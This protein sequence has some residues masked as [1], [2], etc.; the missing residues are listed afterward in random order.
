MKPL[1]MNKY[2]KKIVISKPGGYDCL[3][4]KNAPLE[5]MENLQADELLIK[6][7]AAGVN[8]A[9]VC[10]RWGLYSSAKKFVGWPITPGFEFSGYIVATGSKVETFKPGIPVFGISFFGAYSQ[11]LVVKSWQ[12]YPLLEQY[13]FTLEQAAG[14]PAV[15]LTAYH[16]LYQNIII[17]PGMKILIHSAAG[18]VGQALVQLAHRLKLEVTAVIGSSRK[19]DYVNKILK[20]QYIIDKSKQDLWEAAH[21]ISPRGFDIIADANG[22]ATLKK[23]YQHLAPM[24][25]LLIY[26]FH[27][28]LPR[29]GGKISL[30]HRL[31]LAIDY[32]KTPRFNPLFMTNQNKS[33][34][35][36]NLSYL[37]CYQNLYKQAMQDLLNAFKNGELMAPPVTSY[38]LEEVALAHAA[39]ESGKTHGKL[40]LLMNH[41]K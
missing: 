31:N 12:I 6:V 29:K 22:V 41:E 2:G 23:S 36:F 5:E 30:K 32:L 13:P 25:K 9:D 37:F 3:E 28:M 26:G 8:Y 11:W 27:S 14:I 24:G 4:V 34:V 21:H 15:F 1:P 18:G 17:R 16:A 33:I 39:I 19:Y 20:P 10:V 38:A 7:H 40:I 35:T